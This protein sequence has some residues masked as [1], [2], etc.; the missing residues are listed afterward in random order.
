MNASSKRNQFDSP[1]WRRMLQTRTKRTE[2]PQQ[3]SQ[4]ASLLQRSI[5]IALLIAPGAIAFL[6]TR[7]FAAGL[8]AAVVIAVSASLA[9]VWAS[10]FLN[11]APAP[12]I[13]LLMTA[14]FILAFLFSP[15][16]RTRAGD[17]KPEAGALPPPASRGSVSP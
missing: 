7:R 9:G 6:I 14:C 12:T 13:V 3:K 8:I 11:S 1:C 15:N 2:A 16:R 5:A 10:F 17:E 4:H